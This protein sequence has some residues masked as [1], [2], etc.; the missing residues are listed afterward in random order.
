[1]PEMS[2]SEKIKTVLVS[3]GFNE[4]DLTND[5]QIVLWLKC[6]LANY[7]KAKDKLK[8]I[9]DILVPFPD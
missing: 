5:E 9:K 2:L 7:E 4:G 3:F 1:M 8:Q 6:T